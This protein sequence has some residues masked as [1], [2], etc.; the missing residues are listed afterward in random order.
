MTGASTGINCV[1]TETHPVWWD[2]VCRLLMLT[3]E[4]PKVLSKYV[5]ALSDE[6]GIINLTFFKPSFAPNS[7]HS[8]KGLHPPKKK[9]PLA[10]PIVRQQKMGRRWHRWMLLTVFWKRRRALR[11]D[12]HSDVTSCSRTA[13]TVSLPH[14]QQSQVTGSP[15]PITIKSA[16]RYGGRPLG[17]RQ[18]KRWVTV[19]FHLVIDV[20]STDSNTCKQKIKIK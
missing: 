3:G 6:H 18:G 2:V 4:T 1:H 9:Y 19:C 17:R 5:C 12:P 13:P 14:Q 16:S 15:P 11:L 7:L 20:V 8:M 10:E